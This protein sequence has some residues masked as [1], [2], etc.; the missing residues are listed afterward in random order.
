VPDVILPRD[1]VRALVPQ[2]LAAT[3]AISADWAG[4]SS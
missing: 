3:E 1:G 2:L 4:R